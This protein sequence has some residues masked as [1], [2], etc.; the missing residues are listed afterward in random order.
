MYAASGRRPV[1]GSPPT[2]DEVREAF[3]SDVADALLDV[4]QRRRP[5]RAAD[6]AVLFGTDP[7]EVSATVRVR[8]LPTPSFTAT[9][10]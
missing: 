8:A 9:R 1:A 3:G 2:L 6:V 5:R 10:R 4:D 7:D